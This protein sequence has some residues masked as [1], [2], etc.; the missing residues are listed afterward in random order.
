MEDVAVA[1]EEGVEDSDSQVRTGKQSAPV[2]GT[3]ANFN[4]INTNIVTKMMGSDTSLVKETC[5]LLLENKR[6]DYFGFGFSA[7]QVYEEMVRLLA[8]EAPDII[9]EITPEEDGTSGSKK[10]ARR[11]EYHVPTGSKDDDVYSDSETEENVEKSAIT[12]SHKQQRQGAGGTVGQL[13]LSN[14]WDQQTTSQTSNDQ[15]NGK[16]SS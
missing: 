16:G 1:E 2:L 12:P 3:V 14:M 11:E 4:S 13:I 7:E 9:R 8:M 5:N 6:Q 10:R 15:Q